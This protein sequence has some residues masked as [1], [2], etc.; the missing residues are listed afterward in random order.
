MSPQRVGSP[1]QPQTQTLTER[2][3][4]A[5]DTALT[6]RSAVNTAAVV[7]NR[8]T[9]AYSA[10]KNLPQKAPSLGFSGVAGRLNSGAG[11][12]VGGALLPGQIATASSDIRKAV[13]SGTREDATQAANSTLGAARNTLVSSKGS[14]E[15]AQN[16]QKFYGARSAAAAAFAQSAPEASKSV[17]KAASRAAARATFHNGTEAAATQ[18]VERAVSGAGER[19]AQAAL[20]EGSESAAR[21]AAAATARAAAGPVSKAA[22][23]FIPGVNVALAAVDSANATATLANPSA[24]VGKKVTSV[25]TAAGSIAAATN[26]PVVSQAG[27]A[28]SLASSFASGFFK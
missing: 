14:V 8:V 7:K 3:N 12:V 25:I 13:S 11:V 20:R 21:A 6:A 5:T 4:E 1:P 19:A 26:V 27:A 9:D 23:R 15:L 28:L 22:G 16:A 2:A 18:A 10:A 24:G 17:V